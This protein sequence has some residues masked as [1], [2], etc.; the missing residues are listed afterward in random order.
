MEGE[1]VFY[2]QDG[3]RYTGSLTQN[4]RTGRGVFEWV[5]GERYEGMFE[6]GEC[7]GQGL[8]TWADGTYCQGTFES[9]VQRGFGEFVWSNGN[10]Y[11]GEFE[12]DARHGHGRL[13]QKN[14][15]VVEGWWKKDALVENMDASVDPSRV[16]DL[17]H[18][19][20]AEAI[21]N[22]VCTFTVTGRESYAQFFYETRS[23][24]GRS[25][26]LCVVCAQTCAKKS[27]VLFLQEEP[28][29]GGNFYCDCGAGH[30]VG[31]H[32]FA[33]QTPSV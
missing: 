3:N 12:K 19:K 6:K 5:S 17:L 8:F 23:V 22:R 10:R 32:C 7:T 21:E 18:P 4:E 33:L 31:S 1:G 15:H 29:F 2:Y 28:V 30:E 26:G 27:G 13:I 20:V 24:D 11:V 25:H 9:G 14:G 16:M